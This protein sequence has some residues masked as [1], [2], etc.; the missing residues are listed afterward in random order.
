MILN[1]RLVTFSYTSPDTV[2]SCLSPLLSLGATE[3]IPRE[4]CKAK[5]RRFAPL[6]F[7]RGPLLFLANCSLVSPA[8][9][10][11]RDATPAGRLRYIHAGFTRDIFVL[12]SRLLSY[13]P[14]HS[15]LR[16]RRSVTSP[17]SSSRAT[18]RRASLPPRF[19]SL[20]AAAPL[21]PAC[22]VPCIYEGGMAE[23]EGTR[24]RELWPE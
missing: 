18:R 17:F 9:N 22:L 10:I 7:L 21:L 13:P 1:V 14:V 3:T 15:P 20:S 2:A 6:S 23:A 12:K 11:S 24:A 16:L 19:L 5:R 4:I 8:R